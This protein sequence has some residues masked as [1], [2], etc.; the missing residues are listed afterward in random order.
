VTHLK[1]FFDAPRMWRNSLDVLELLIIG[2]DNHFEP[3]TGVKIQEIQLKLFG[4]VCEKFDIFVKFVHK[5]NENCQN[6]CARPASPVA[7][8]DS[9]AKEVVSV[10]KMTKK[11]KMEDYTIYYYNNYF[12]QCINS[13]E[14][15][16]QF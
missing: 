11:F 14:I 2:S 1:P 8:I 10:V 15:S 12:E 3:E 4:N 16:R 7:R 6:G 9:V 13:N 5:R